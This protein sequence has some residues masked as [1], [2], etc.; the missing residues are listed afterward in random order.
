MSDQSSNK[1]LGVIEVS[2]I[3][4]DSE[5]DTD[6]DDDDD[7]S[8]N[9]STKPPESPP[10]D[11]FTDD[12]EEEEHIITPPP[13][14][15]P[16]EIESQ[17]PKNESVD[18]SVDSVVVTP[19][20][21]DDDDA[22]DEPIETEDKMEIDD[23]VT[24]EEEEEEESEKLSVETILA[25]TFEIMSKKRMLKV[26]ISPDL[27]QKA[28]EALQKWNDERGVITFRTLLN[29]DSALAQFK[30]VANKGNKR[31][32]F[33]FKPVPV[34]TKKV[35]K[36]EYDCLNCQE[37]FASQDDYKTHFERFHKNCSIQDGNVFPKQPK[38][39][40]WLEKPV[41]SRQCE[42]ICKDCNKELTAIEVEDHSTEMLHFTIEKLE[43]TSVVANNKPLGDSSN[44][45]IFYE[46]RIFTEKR[47]LS[48][49][50]TNT[51]IL[52]EKTY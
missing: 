47:H 42:F 13:V 17:V 11:L 22:N 6:D 20:N 14:L 41:K 28:D 16:N 43:N 30:S 26:Y 49:C 3:S 32:A 9:A 39:R 51:Q 38:R 52:S 40:P 48:C 24:E 10:G 27:R 2:T 15:T 25:L 19:A 44:Q 45:V 12:E 34:P 5:N 23:K 31:P 36:T 18:Q 37:V 1:K 46:I 29:N 8:S 4:D 33:N 21:N 35:K 7:V 50:S